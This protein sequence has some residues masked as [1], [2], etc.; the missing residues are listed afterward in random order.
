MS[1]TGQAADGLG[2]RGYCPLSCHLTCPPPSTRNLVWTKIKADNPVSS[3]VDPSAP[4]QS[5][6]M[7]LAIRHP[8][9]ARTVISAPVDPL[10]TSIAPVSLATEVEITKELNSLHSLNLTER[11]E[12]KHDS[13]L[14]TAGLGGCKLVMVGASNI[15]KIVALTRHSGSTEAYEVASV[16]DTAEGSGEGGADA[17]AIFPTKVKQ[18]Q[19]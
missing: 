15:A 6:D 16:S 17:L 3:S 8:L 18:G 11:P 12:I 10:P 14:P 13:G 4:E 5:L 2:T 19:K 1:C 9:K 7:P